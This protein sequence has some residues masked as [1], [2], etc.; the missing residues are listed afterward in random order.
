MQ[1]SATGCQ[2]GHCRSIDPPIRPGAKEII[3][4][5]KGRRWYRPSASSGGGGASLAR[6]S[7]A[8]QWGWLG[9]PGVPFHWV[10]GSMSLLIGSSNLVLCELNLEWGRGWSHSLC[11]LIFLCLG[12]CIAVAP[13]S[14]L[15]WFSVRLIKWLPWSWASWAEICMSDTISSWLCAKDALLQVLR[16]T[17]PHMEPRG[18]TCWRIVNEHFILKKWSLCAGDVQS[19]NFSVFWVTLWVHSEDLFERNVHWIVLCLTEAP[20]AHS[21]TRW[22]ATW[23]TRLHSSWSPCLYR[24]KRQ[25]LF[26][27]LDILK[28]FP[29]GYWKLNAG[30][31]RTVKTF[32]NWCSSALLLNFIIPIYLWTLSKQVEFDSKFSFRLSLSI[33]QR[34]AELRLPRYRYG[35]PGCRP[36]LAPFRAEAA[37]SWGGWCTSHSTERCQ[38]HSQKQ[39]R[40]IELQVGLF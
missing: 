1:H 40:D 17:H 33:L 22:T 31:W 29:T 38:L 26:A 15:T 35:N 32:K 2:K 39:A 6:C 4:P 23:P 36:F 20:A 12:E 13:T 37:S 9:L 7:R 11:A 5:R 28:S 24:Q 18:E 25:T 34:W 16:V 21:S 30:F 8:E 19:S 14:S 27:I 3:S 10:P